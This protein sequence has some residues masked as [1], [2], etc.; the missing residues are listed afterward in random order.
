[1]RLVKTVVWSSLLGALFGAVV[2]ILGELIWHM[3]QCRHLIEAAGIGAFLGLISGLFAGI[4]KAI[5]KA[6]WWRALIVF[7]QI[8]FIGAA[9]GFFMGIFFGISTGI[10]M[11]TMSAGTVTTLVQHFQRAEAFLR[12]NLIAGEV[13]AVVGAIAFDTFILFAL[14]K[15]WV[16]IQGSSRQ[17]GA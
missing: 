5:D 6:E 7:L 8:T 10:T 2:V 17:R 3:G 9:V 14:L 1:M 15:G 12:A 13:G 4:V 11:P 16:M